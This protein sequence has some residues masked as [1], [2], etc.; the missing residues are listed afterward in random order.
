MNVKMNM[1]FLVAGLFSLLVSCSCEERK[2]DALQET[3]EFERVQKNF[4]PGE[5]ER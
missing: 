1:K 2:L 5:M 4:G 3:D